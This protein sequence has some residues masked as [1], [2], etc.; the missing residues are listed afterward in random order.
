MLTPISLIKL[1][2]EDLQFSFVLNCTKIVLVKSHV[3][4]SV[5]ADSGFSS[6]C[7]DL[8]GPVPA[9]GGCEELAVQV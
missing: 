8:V 7:V 3:W 2:G 5:S 9:S 4:N 1:C 6:A